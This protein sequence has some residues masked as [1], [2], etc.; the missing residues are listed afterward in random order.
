MKQGLRNREQEGEL[1]TPWE[2]FHT[3]CMG[4][5]QGEEASPWGAAREHSK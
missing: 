1:R 4:T 2:A 5:D 3:Q